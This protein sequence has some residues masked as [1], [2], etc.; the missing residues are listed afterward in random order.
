[1]R[2]TLIH[3][4]PASFSCFNFVTHYFPTPNPNTNTHP[5]SSM[6]P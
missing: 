6:W 1:L 4:N 3:N 2:A 5:C